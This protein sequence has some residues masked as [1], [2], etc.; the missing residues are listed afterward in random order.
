M[1]MKKQVRLPGQWVDKALMIDGKPVGKSRWTPLGFLDWGYGEVD[2][3][4]A[5]QTSHRV[6][7][8][9]GLRNGWV[10]YK[11]DFRAAFFQGDF[12]E[13]DNV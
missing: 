4:V 7:E 9:V 3:P 8:A 13:R 5:D 6:G 1:Q 11:V 2:S 10:E 12:S